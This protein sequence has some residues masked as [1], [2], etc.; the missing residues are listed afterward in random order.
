MVTEVRE[1][2]AP[3][4]P[5]LDRTDPWWRGAA[6]PTLFVLLVAAGVAFR[7]YST[8][9]LWLDEAQ[10]VAIAQLPL[11]HLFGALR[12][13]GSP[14]LYYLL[15]HGWIA[16]FGTSAAAVRSLSTVLAL[17]A[18]PLAWLA[19]WQLTRR[20]SVAWSALLLLA[21][22]PFAIRYATETR[23]YALEMLLALL[24][25]L[26]LLAVRRRPGPLPVLALALVT[27]LLA[28]THYWA[29]Y[30]IAVVG[31]SALWYAVRGPDRDP[32]RRALLGLAL[33]GLLF[34]PWLP[35]LLYQS[36]HTGTPWAGLPHWSNVVDTVGGWAQGSGYL[37]LG[38]WALAVLGV[39][40]RSESTRRLLLELPARPLGRLLAVA[41]GAT[42]LV[43]V[44]AGMLLHSAYSARYSAFVLAPFLLLTALG[45][46]IL[47]P[48]ARHAAIAVV[49]VLG[50][51][52]GAPSMWT[53]RSS[54]AQVARILRAHA[55]S[56]DLVV[57]CPD[58]LGPPVSRLLSDQLRQVVYPSFGSPERIDWVDY[59]RRNRS[60]NPGVFA[61]LTELQAA[62]GASI[63]L[64][65]ASNYRTFG[66][67]CARLR[68]LFAVGRP[69]GVTAR[70]AHARGAERVRVLRFPAQ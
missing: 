42:L 59:A 12:Q 20:K 52:V 17:A 36:A 54:A 65:Y 38:Y 11:D 69:N 41:T 18:L 51:I 19:A 30:L 16:A 61:A 9:V 45:A 34:V 4:T 26:A 21:A 58:Q 47:A 43:A 10:S 63:W 29:L 67:D 7:L 13:D 44:V 70:I 23:M 28:L 56:D 48:R 3:P 46:D 62:P 37:V 33:G 50:L 64:V 53:P 55:A 2:P 1:I 49:A 32:A 60:S 27:G 35:T 68:E 5:D 31:V 66:D 25:V 22:S 15:L 6:W 39:F 24:G 8:S 14:P 40:G 57:Y